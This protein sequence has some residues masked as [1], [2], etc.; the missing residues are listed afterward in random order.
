MSSILSYS[1][2]GYDPV[3]GLYIGNNKKPNQN[4]N[5]GSNREWPP[6]ERFLSMKGTKNDIFSIV[7]GLKTY[8]PGIIHTD[9]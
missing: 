1:G 7:I 6:K 4:P 2:D 5:N 3:T 9:C 8:C